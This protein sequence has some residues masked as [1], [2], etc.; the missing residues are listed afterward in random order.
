MNTKILY[1]ELQ[2]Q[3]YEHENCKERKSEWG[4]ACTHNHALPV[5]N[6]A[7]QSLQQEMSAYMDVCTHI[8]TLRNLFTKTADKHY[9]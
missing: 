8:Q 6:N 9:I 1:A 7:G 4:N 5:D 3:L 2:K